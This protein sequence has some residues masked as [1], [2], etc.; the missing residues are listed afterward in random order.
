MVSRLSILGVFSLLSN[1]P[2]Y[3]DMAYPLLQ[4]VLFLRDLFTPP[5]LKPPEEKSFHP[6][7]PPDVGVE[8]QCGHDNR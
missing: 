7:S 2:F 4:L 6:P 1:S 5:T 8:E 3:V